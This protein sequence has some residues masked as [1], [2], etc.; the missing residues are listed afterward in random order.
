MGVVGLGIMGSAI[1][2]NLVRSG[3]SVIGYDVA[4]KYKEQSG[5]IRMD[6]KPGDRL[7]MQDGAILVAAKPAS[8]PNG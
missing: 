6:D 7:P 3:Q 4:W 1:A 5:V 2:A 8:P